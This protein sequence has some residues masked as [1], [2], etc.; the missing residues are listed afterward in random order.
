MKIVKILPLTDENVLFAGHDTDYPSWDAG[1]TYPK[2]ATVQVDSPFA[3]VTINTYLGAV[4]N[5]V[6][7]TA[8]ELKDETPVI[9][10]TSGALPN[11]NP[12]YLAYGSVVAGRAYY[13]RNYP[14][15]SDL[16]A[17]YFQLADTPRGS[18]KEIQ[19]TQS[20]VHT[21]TASTHKVY[22]SLQAAN[23]GKVPRA[24][25]SS[26]WW[27]DRGSTN[28]WKRFDDSVT[29]QSRDIALFTTIQL[30]APADFLGL[31]NIYGALV[32][33]SLT[34]AVAGEI[35]NKT[36]SLISTSGI[37]DFWSWFFTPIERK[38]SFMLTDLP[39]SNDAVLSVL[40]QEVSPESPCLC[41]KFAVGLS[42]GAGG[43][44]YGA[45]IGF[46]DFS[47]KTQNGWGDYE[48]QERGWSAKANFA[49]M[50]PTGSIE[51]FLNLLTS[52]RATPAVYIGAVNRP[53]T[54]LIGWAKDMSLV[55]EYENYS[56]LNTE[57]EGLV[58]GQN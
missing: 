24:A 37:D 5:S 9:F 36:H 22:E 44:N 40:I 12:T 41:G 35:Y 45:S 18:V 48:V 55:I 19:G 31:M 42:L 27:Q 25:S 51:R 49:T 1:V 33:V 10:T 8:H 20:G 11:G 13:V 57:I 43:T 34:D 2:G 53:E 47:V 29:S 16:N 54:M 4:P 17:N 56:L 21:G 6:G 15:T 26:T 30:R 52:L 39:V 38:T 32:S 46:Q 3:T 28:K 58:C 14:A 7:W 23:L 50:V